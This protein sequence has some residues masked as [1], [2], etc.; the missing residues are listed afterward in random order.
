MS[1]RNRF[2]PNLWRRASP[3]DYDYEVIED[4][5]LLENTG[6]G[7]EAPDAAVMLEMDD[8][9]FDVP[10]FSAEVVS[11]T[12]DI[13]GTVFAVVGG[14]TQGLAVVGI[15]V[16]AVM[17]IVQSLQEHASMNGWLQN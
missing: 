8:V 9:L 13:V 11:I 5:D 12:S 6:V 7:L 1:L 2:N 3:G 4:L 15:L 14:V 17:A 16:T 10:L